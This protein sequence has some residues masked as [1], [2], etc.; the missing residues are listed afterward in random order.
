[1]SFR[2][3]INIFIVFCLSFLL[4]FAILTWESTPVKSP[5][6]L[7]L[8]TV[9]ACRSDHISSY[10]NAKMKTP[11]LEA[12]ANDGVCFLN[13]ISASPL[14]LPSY[15][16]LLTGLYPMAHGVKDNIGF[17]LTADQLSL[18]EILY[19]EGYH[20][21]AFLSSQLLRG[22][23]GLAQGFEKYF[24]LTPSQQLD[25]KAEK[26]F[27]E[28]QKWMLQQ[29]QSS[30]GQLLPEDQRVPF[31]S[32]IQL[33][34][35][36]LPY[37]PPEAFKSEYP[38][39]PYQGEIASI[40]QQI[41]IFIEFLKQLDLY[42][43]SLIVFVG[44]HGESLG[45]HGEKG[46]GYFLYDE[47]LKVPFLMKLPQSSQKGKRIQ[48]QVRTIDLLPT[49]LQL[50]QVQVPENL[51]GF[52][53]FPLILGEVETLQLT[54]YSETYLPFYRYGVSPIK[55]IRTTR[56]KWIESREK[57]LY[58]LQNDPQEKKNI[59]GKDPELDGKLSRQFEAI[60]K[61]YSRENFAAQTPDPQISNTLSSLGYPGQAVETL[62]K[63]DV[64]M[65]ILPS[66]QENFPYHQALY[67]A[68]Q[69]VK[70]R[71]YQ[72]AQSH[73]NIVLT[74]YP[75]MNFAHDLQLS[76]FMG[77]NQNK[78]ALQLLEQI[79]EKNPNNLLALYR[80]AI[81]LYSLDKQAEAQEVLKALLKKVPNH[82]SARRD[83]WKIYLISKQFETAVEEINIEIQK[84]P[85]NTFAWFWL[86][87]TRR[88]QGELELAKKAYYNAT[89][90]EYYASDAYYE[91]TKLYL[92]ENNV[93]KAVEAVN[94]CM[95]LLGENINGFVNF[96]LIFEKNERWKEAKNYFQKALSFEPK[97]PI[98][99]HK[100]IQMSLQLQKNSLA[101]Q[102]IQKAFEFSLPLQYQ[103]KFCELLQQIG[104][105]TE[106]EKKALQL[107]QAEP[108]NPKVLC[109]LGC[110][111]E[112]QNQKDKALTYLED[113]L[114]NKP[115]PKDEEKAKTLLEKLRK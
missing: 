49:L 25:Q 85:N 72:K 43:Q 113:C 10:P 98:L 61:S 108:Q 96:G 66:A 47:S 89:Q 83:L 50:L 20:T 56:Y 80:K 12:L 34:D 55:A 67:Q 18:A 111:Y 29:C 52:S 5:K 16:T 53:L 58:D 93:Q 109:F 6:N 70:A 54:A 107:Y 79:L 33:F 82:H 17:Q 45:E 110:F 15:A 76:I 38:E 92:K 26:V 78:E 94:Q 59:L 71:N 8:I 11:G 21:S 63:G 73:L 32:W 87:E 14:T 88:Q 64:D 60:Q 3:I 7:I 81:C 9:D 102:E 28:T 62:L 22:E 36:H 77:L 114:K 99:L 39:N 115:D 42:D 105:S 4:L 46:H 90:D 69:E 86:G 95:K 97:N 30:N 27:Y 91:L 112:E 104:N 31:F 35:P 24:E 23:T 19:K 75:W 48:D 100:N 2:K 13:T 74:R 41:Q 57:E 51:Q 103:L 44:N 106:A 37:D 1:M 65:K 68:A 40:D 101:F 84:D